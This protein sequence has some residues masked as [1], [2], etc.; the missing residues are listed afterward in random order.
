M[1]SLFESIEFDKT[2][3][4]FGS[5][6]AHFGGPD[7]TNSSSVGQND[8]R[9]GPTLNRG[10]VKGSPVVPGSAKKVLEEGDWA[11]YSITALRGHYEAGTIDNDVVN[12]GSFV[13]YVEPLKLAFREKRFVL[14]D[15]KYDATKTGGVDAEISRAQADLQSLQ[16]SLMQYC[17][18]YFSE[19][20]AGLMHLKAV[21][22][23]AESVLR[24][25][26]PFDVVS[27]AIDA[28]MKREKQYMTNLQAGLLKL[29]PHL[30]V[31]KGLLDDEEE[32]DNTDNLPFVCHKFTPIGV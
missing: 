31:K 24:Y 19:A 7:W 30:A 1:Q 18:A 29:C 2:Y 5:E 6:I 23:F 12:P 4:S 28:D 14:R 32:A 20:T 22:I 27:V 8:G 11:L 9:F 15:F 13:D 26:I 17:V 16:K 21:K 10:S 3:S 25:G